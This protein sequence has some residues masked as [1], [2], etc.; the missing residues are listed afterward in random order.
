[1]AYI[2]FSDWYDYDDMRHCAYPPILDNAMTPEYIDGNMVVIATKEE[3]D[4][5][6]R[7]LTDLSKQISYTVEDSLTEESGGIITL[8]TEKIFVYSQMP[9]SMLHAH[10]VI[11]VT[12]EICDYEQLLPSEEDVRNRIMEIV[13]ASTPFCE[14]PADSTIEKKA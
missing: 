3:A 4:C 6:V 8:F 2:L 1:M 14:T 12:P 5:I 11:C 10:D 9:D 13:D 7:T